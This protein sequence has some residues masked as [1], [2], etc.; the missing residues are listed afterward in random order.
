MKSL[1]LI[2]DTQQQ[3]V[4]DHSSRLPTWTSSVYS[5]PI[6]IQMS[7][8]LLNVVKQNQLILLEIQLVLSSIALSVL[9]WTAV[10]YYKRAVVVHTAP[11][12]YPW[13]QI[14]YHPV[15]GNLLNYMALIVMF[16]FFGTL[17]YI[18]KRDRSEL[19][20]EQ[21]VRRASPLAAG[22]S[23]CL[24]AIILS[25]CAIKPTAKA[26]LLGCAVVV[27]LALATPVSIVFRE[28][29]NKTTFPSNNRV[30]LFLLLGLFVAV[31]F[32]P[33]RISKGPVYLM[34]EYPDIYGETLIGKQFINNKQFLNHLEE[35]DICAIDAFRDM[36][37]SSR[38][39]PGAENPPAS[40]SEFFVR[41][42]STDL[43]RLQGYVNLLIEKG[44]L[45]KN[46]VTDR[47]RRH[48]SLGAKTDLCVKNIR[49]VDMEVTKHFF[50]TNL[51]E[52][53]HQ[54]MGRGQINHFGHI[55]NPIN[56]I[57]LGKPVG[58]TYL[59]YG[60]GN[61]FLM[62]WIMDLF[63]GFSIQNY[64]KVYILYVLYYFLFLIMVITLFGN[65]VFAV[66]AFAAVPV[67]FFLQGY[68]ALVLGPGI[69]PSIH[70]LDTSVIICL[71]CFFRRGN[72]IWLGVG[73]AMV[74]A[75]LSLNGQYGLALLAAFIVSLG[76]YGLEN[77]SGKARVFWLFFLVVLTL[78]AVTV[79]R[80]SAVGTLPGVFLYFWSGFFSWPVHPAVATLTILYLAVSYSFLIWLRP[81]RHYLKYI[82]V[83]L[84]CY[85]Q[86]L[87]VYFYWS[88][89]INH[90]PPILPFLCL[91]LFVMLYIGMKNLAVRPLLQKICSASV[92]ALTLLLTVLTLPSGALFY[93]ER[94]MFHDN[95]KNHRIYSW[96]F[97]RA[98]VITT[99]DPLIMHES[100]RLIQ[101]YSNTANPRVYILSKYDSL[102]PF[103]SERYSAMPFFDLTSYLFSERE[104]KWVL[105]TITRDKPRY[106][107]V[108]TQINNYEVDRWANLYD[109]PLFTYERVSRLE[110]YE[111]LFRIFQEVKAAYRAIDKG[112]LITVYERVS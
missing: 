78:L 101:R 31:A 48:E 27:L 83:F 37:T 112:Q 33:L 63:G 3:V 7:T 29:L 87:L 49:N 73:A 62:K 2:Q 96:K 54:N 26:S 82:Y 108:D 106:L 102:L 28:Y 22:G 39:L 9:C 72:R 98:E 43:D 88:G 77:R 13:T 20:L 67:S 74:V 85:A 55:L 5:C 103:L 34:N 71:L 36:L 76:L 32:E 1:S 80:L 30:F 40:N 110:R 104:Y 59:Q 107:F 23:V 19:F 47:S 61:T 95:F 8:K 42:R 4:F 53:N 60:L 94:Q 10:S 11:V 90:L 75:S 16:G 57:S 24:S 79:W 38:L 109:G 14:F 65:R 99:V 51:L 41:Y 17:A 46:L 70:L 21:N 56:E 50:V 66:G 12:L 64:Y 97:P 100:V 92:V 69:I 86:V 58:S 111:L 93:K 81:Q 52:Y 45:P 68:I 91:Q 18:L 44:G 25:F 105:D 35:K 84:F 6:T 15:E 89:L